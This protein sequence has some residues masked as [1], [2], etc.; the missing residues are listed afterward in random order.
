MGNSAGK[1]EGQNTT[2]T[3]ES[4]NDKISLLSNQ[5][6]SEND[7]V[8]I[9]CQ[10]ESQSSLKKGDL[11]EITG[12]NMSPSPVRCGSSADI[13]PTSISP[14]T[15]LVNESV[16]QQKNLGVPL[17]NDSMLY[18]QRIARATEETEIAYVNGLVSLLE[19]D[20]LEHSE[21]ANRLSRNVARKTDK[22]NRL[23]VKKTGRK[24]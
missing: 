5:Q 3:Q 9:N 11:T 6:S 4:A 2:M 7:P 1:S 23:K 13:Q 12:K 21:I 18:H 20:Q 16:S 10:V 15:P 19:I 8:K 14:P 22:N 17:Q 24:H